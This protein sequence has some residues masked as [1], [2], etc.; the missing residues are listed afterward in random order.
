MRNLDARCGHMIMNIGTKV[1][2][3]RLKDRMLLRRSS[4]GGAFVAISDYF[5]DNN[6]A[7]VCAVYDYENHATE[8][9]LIESKE[10]RDKAIGSKYMQSKPGQVYRDAEKWLKEH[11]EKK[12]LFVGMGCQADGFRKFSE[13]RGFRERVCVVD[14]ICHGSPSPKLWRKYAESIEK[15]NG[16]IT[17]LTF[18]D[19]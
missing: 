17:Y 2:A 3:G 1:Y 5:L 10:E 18:K 6:N 7:V 13:I 4:S 16:K 15:K 8:F 19:K 14:I 12:L 9:H 11:S